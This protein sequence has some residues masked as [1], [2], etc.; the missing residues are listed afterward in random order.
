MLIDLDALEED[1]AQEELVGRIGSIDDAL[2]EALDDGVLHGDVAGGHAFGIVQVDEHAL[3]GGIHGEVL[4]AEVAHFGAAQFEGAHDR[5]AGLALE[6]ER[7][8]DGQHAAEVIFAGSEGD[9]I[10]AGR[11]GGKQLVD[12]VDDQFRI[13]AAATLRQDRKGGHAGSGFGVVDIGGGRVGI[14]LDGVAA[15]IEHAGGGAANHELSALGDRVGLALEDDGVASGALDRIPTDRDVSRVAGGDGGRIRLRSRSRERRVDRR[16]IL[17]PGQLLEA[18]GTGREDVHKRL[19]GNGGDQDLLG[20]GHVGESGDAALEGDFTAVHRADA[21]DEMMTR[22]LGIRRLDQE[23]TGTVHLEG[24]VSDRRDAGAV[25]DGR[26]LEGEHAVLADDVV[27][28]G[29][30]DV[31]VVADHL[32]LDGTGEVLGVAE[33]PGLAAR[34]QVEGEV[35]RLFHEGRPP[36]GSTDLL[37]RDFAVGKDVEEAARCVVAG[38][39]AQDGTGGV[40]LREVG[41]EIADGTVIPDGEVVEPVVGSRHAHVGR[42]H[43]LDVGAGQDGL[44]GHVQEQVV[45][46]GEGSRSDLQAE[47]A[48]VVGVVDEVQVLEG[49]VLEHEFAQAAC[50]E[51]DEGTHALPDGVADEAQALDGRGLADV[52]HV[53]A[54]GTVGVDVVDVATV[55]QDIAQHHV[56]APFIDETLGVVG[57][58][59]V[60]V[61]DV[62]DVLVLEGTAILV[63]DGETET[64]RTGGG[65]TAIQLDAFEVEVRTGRPGIGEVE[66]ALDDGLG[67][68]GGLFTVDAETIGDVQRLDVVRRAFHLEEDLRT[69]GLDRVQQGVQGRYGGGGT[70]VGRR[71]GIHLAAGGAEVIEREHVLGRST[72]AVDGRGRSCDLTGA[73]RVAAQGIRAGE[74]V[75]DAVHLGIVRDILGPIEGHGVRIAG[76]DFQEQVV[77]DGEGLE[78]LLQEADLGILLAAG[79]GLHGAPVSLVGFQL[80][81]E[82]DLGRQDSLAEV[83]LGAR[84]VGVNAED[85]GFGI[86]AHI[87]GKGDDIA[88]GG[89]HAGVQAHRRQAASQVYLGDLLE[90]ILLAGSK[91][92]EG[93]EGQDGIFDLSHN[94]PGIKCCHSHNRS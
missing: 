72:Q 66:L 3:A 68:V 51:A 49:V 61:G 29:R 82:R 16:H 38:I 57:D 22:G 93:Q 94:C 2:G 87:P 27:G 64:G 41:G 60:L 47:Y 67:A 17:G 37:V 78:G 44:P 19:P 54:H 33:V 14:H 81:R 52:E 26:G 85:V 90:D 10:L 70:H 5:R 11:D 59:A 34:N 91:G 50:I 30:V 36:F 25:G 53:A 74:T 55:V 31:Q 23:R 77:L 8:G 65:G 45:L 15:R 86:L 79:R 13:L 76:R 56:V 6:G 40:G 89:T 18:D 46:E 1:V 62:A 43:V 32:F 7:S 88:Q 39:R 4:Q 42:R 21:D 35:L 63:L 24:Q 58:D 9:G 69:G 28:F 92:S 80:L 83:L 71:P 20:V 48:G 12:R 84:R 75:F 73:Q